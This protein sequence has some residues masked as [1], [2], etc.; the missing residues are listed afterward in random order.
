MCVCVRE[1]ERGSTSQGSV[2]VSSVTSIIL[3]YVDTDDLGCSGETDQSLRITSTRRSVWAENKFYF[4][5][6]KL[7]KMKREIH[8]A[9]LHDHFLIY[10]KLNTE[11][12]ITVRLRFKYTTY[13]YAQMKEYNAKSSPQQYPIKNT[14][15][16]SRLI[17]LPSVT[18]TARF[19]LHNMW[20]CFFQCH[21]LADWQTSENYSTLSNMLHISC[22]LV[23]WGVLCETQ[24][25]KGWRT[26]E[27]CRLIIG[28]DTIKCCRSSKHDRCNEL[29]QKPQVMSEE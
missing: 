12:T 8:A 11:R 15:R 13:K 19:T 27:D 21:H 20:R 4:N 7:Q 16:M 18:H 23:M 28:Y 24:V 9:R 14:S 22:S 6:M 26:L 3:L 2:S 17:I 1:W 25:L 10:S 29:K 5:R